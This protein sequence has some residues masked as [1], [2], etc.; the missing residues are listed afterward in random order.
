MRNLFKLLM[1]SVWL[2]SLLSMVYACSEEDD[3]SMTNN[4]GMMVCE[5][6]TFEPGTNYVVNDTLDSLTVTAFGTDSVLINRMEA[7]HSISLP[8]RYTE[9]STKLVFHYTERLTDTLVVR[10][11]NTPYFVSM[12]CGYQ[13]QQSITE[14]SCTYRYLDSLYV[15]NP[16][17]SIDGTENIR[18]FC[19]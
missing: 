8:L 19:N 11:T 14:V 2:Y 16:E 1:V 7:V 4:R 5:F 15:S 3:C 12:D 6:Y 17:T 13:M 10:H 18:F 9:D